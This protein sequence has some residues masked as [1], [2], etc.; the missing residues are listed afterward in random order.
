MSRG[1]AGR[2]NHA[3]TPRE[4][5]SSADSAGI[6]ESAAP[7][8]EKEKD[9]EIARLQKREKEHEIEKAHLK[10]ENA[11]LRASEKEKEA[12]NARLQAQQRSSGMISTGLNSRRFA[13]PSAA[14]D[15][16]KAAQDDLKAAR[17]EI[18]ALEA[19]IE[20]L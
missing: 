11:C 6:V 14:Q 8:N 4:S 18:K 7:A 19:K 12:E 17:A 9:Q 13:R 3:N 16:L 2:G 5:S 1:R 20:Q 10:D 15:D